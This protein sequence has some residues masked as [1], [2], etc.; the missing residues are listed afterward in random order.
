MINT[1]ETFGNIYRQ[2]KSG[3]CFLHAELRRLIND[4]KPV[5]AKWKALGI[6]LEVPMEELKAIGA[7]FTGEAGKAQA[8]LQ[9]VVDHWLENSTRPPTG[10]V[11]KEVLEAVGHRQQANELPKG[12]LLVGLGRKTLCLLWE[13]KVTHN[14][15][16]SVLQ[17]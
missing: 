16:Q 1:S 5:A 14:L 12:L 13:V 8:C 3:I 11:I 9:R 15:P 7:L 4:L 2:D 10:E 6:E 17:Q